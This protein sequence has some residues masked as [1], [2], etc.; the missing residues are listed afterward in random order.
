MSSALG[1]TIVA[2]LEERESAH[3]LARIYIWSEP[4]IDKP[5]QANDVLDLQ[6]MSSN[7]G[8]SNAAMGSGRTPQNMGLLNTPPRH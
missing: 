7:E 6:T 8:I 4:T 5:S 3:S 1:M 2:S